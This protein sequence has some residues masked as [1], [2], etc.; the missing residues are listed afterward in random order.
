MGLYN[1]VRLRWAKLYRLEGDIVT[2]KSTIDALLSDIGFPASNKGAG[3]NKVLVE[4]SEIYFALG[5]Y[6]QAEALADALIDLLSEQAMSDI[7]GN[8][9]L[10]KAGLLRAAIRLEGGDASLAKQYL[11][12]ALPHLSYALD[13][14]HALLQEAMELERS[15]EDTIAR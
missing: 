2:A 15:I 4:A 8:L 5:D 13:P 12:A 11:Q 3:L 10:G 6:E 7:P 9:R 14:E 1:G